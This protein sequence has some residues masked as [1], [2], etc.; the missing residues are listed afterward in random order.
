MDRKS[1]PASTSNVGSPVFVVPKKGP[2]KWRMV[3]DM[4]ALNNISKKTALIMPILEEQLNTVAGSTHFGTFDVLAGFDFLPTGENSQKYFNLITPEGAFTMCG[5]P[6]GWVNTPAIYHNRIVTEIL[7]PAGLYEKVERCGALQW[8]DDT[9]LHAKT[10]EDYVEGL[11]K[12]LKAVIA[13]GVRLSIKKCELYNSE[14][15]W[16]GRR[17][18]GEGWNFD[19]K[20]Y[21]KI[22]SVTRPERAWELAQVI[23]LCNWGGRNYAG[24]SSSY[25]GPLPRALPM[26]L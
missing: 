12:F 18:S 5:A 14:V 8:L 19:G 13:K 25:Y 2:K 3:V 1:N 20:F 11:R 7:E 15:E 22:L 6:M 23:Y 24:T 9:L 10:F 17:I 21:D 16:C 4:R 26:L